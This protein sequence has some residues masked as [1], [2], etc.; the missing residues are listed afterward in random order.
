MPYTD[1]WNTTRPAGSVSAKNI[2]DEI[3]LLRLQLQE[4][5]NDVLV[6]DMAADPLVLK[7][8]V[9]GLANDLTRII[10]FCAFLSDL[11]TKENDLDFAIGRIQGF[12][13][14][15]ALFAPVVIPVGCII[16][17]I[18]YLVDIHDVTVVEARFYSVAFSDAPAAATVINTLDMT[19]GGGPKI[20]PTPV[21]A[22]TVDANTTYYVVISP[23]AGTFNNGFF[24]HGVRITFNR[25]ALANAT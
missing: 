3:R 12:V 17:K 21:L 10:P 5:F 8:E 1:G 15:P 4:R 16:T 7:D 23:S 25:P 9:S 18:E 19:V 24:L 14:E 20:F 11:H 13:G 2:D 6:V 22:I